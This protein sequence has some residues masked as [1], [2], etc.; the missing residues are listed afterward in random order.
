MTDFIL[1]RISLGI[2]MKQYKNRIFLSYLDSQRYLNDPNEIFI[3]EYGSISEQLFIDIIRDNAF[4]KIIKKYCFDLAGCCFISFCNEYGAAYRNIY[5][6]GKYIIQLLDRIDMSM[7]PDLV[8][9]FQEIIDYVSFDKY[10]ADHMEQKYSI[11]VDGKQYCV[12]LR[13]IIN[14]LNS[15]SFDDVMESFPPEIYGISTPVFL[16]IVYSYFYSNNLFNKYVS[17]DKLCKRIDFINRFGAAFKSYY[18]VGDTLFIKLEKI[19]YKVLFSFN[20]RA[21]IKIDPEL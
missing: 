21:N 15:D 2:R 8:N 1:Q 18:C 7:Y 6:D 10:I 17:N 5:V 13:D 12:L 3:D 11:K 19:A 9:R 4:Y 20:N 14:I 16:C